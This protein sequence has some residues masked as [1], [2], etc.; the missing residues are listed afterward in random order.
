MQYHLWTFS[1]FNFNNE[2]SKTIKVKK[3]YLNLT[4]ADE[5]NVGESNDLSSSDKLDLNAMY[6]CLGMLSIIFLRR[7]FL[8]HKIFK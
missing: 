8:M 3:S 5:W 4:A 1:K 7:F 2:A 6:G